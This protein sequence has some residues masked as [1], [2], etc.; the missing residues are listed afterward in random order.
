MDWSGLLWCFYQMFG[1]SF[2]RHPFTAEHPLLSKWC[3]ATFLQICSDEETNSSTSWMTRGWVYF[4]A[5]FLFRVKYYFNK[6]QEVD[7][8]TQ[9]SRLILELDH[10]THTH[11]AE[12][13]PEMT[14]LS[15]EQM[16]TYSQKQLPNIPAAH[17][18]SQTSYKVQENSPTNKNWWPRW[19]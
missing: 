17:D 16:N 7:Q 2:W 11:T 5:H 10:V 6:W 8:K 4:S 19:L 18:P 12:A 13:D 14:R 1:L 15:E 9:S 3:K